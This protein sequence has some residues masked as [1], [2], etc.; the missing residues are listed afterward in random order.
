VYLLRRAPLVDKGIRFTRA[1]A[2]NADADTERFEAS[3]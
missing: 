1:P 2:A 3:A